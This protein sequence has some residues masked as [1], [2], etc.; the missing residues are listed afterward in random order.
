[1]WAAFVI[2]MQIVGLV[3][4]AFMT[5]DHFLAWRDNEVSLAADCWDRIKDR[6]S[7]LLKRR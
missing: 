3:I 5:L 6:S 1:M 2:V 4:V 7:E